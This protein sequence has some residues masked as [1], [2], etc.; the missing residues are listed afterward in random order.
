MYAVYILSHKRAER[1]ETYS[2][3]KDSGY[4]GD[5]FVVVDNEDPQL[6]EYEKR[7]GLE[8]T[9]VF[10]KELY[11]SKSDTITNQK[12]KSSPVYARNFI[13]FHAKSLGYDAYI[14]MD[15][16]ITNLRFRYIENSVAKSQ[17]LS[18][19]FGEV[20]DAYVEYLLSNS[21]ATLSLANVM[22]YAGGVK[23]ADAER[24]LGMHRNTCQIHIRN[25]SYDVDWISL[26]NNDSITTDSTAKLGYLW[27]SLPFVVY[28]SPKMNT[29]PGG[30]KEVYD[31]NSG[32]QR[33]F[34]AT[35]ANPSFCKVGCAKDKLNI[36]RNQKHA[37]PMI[38][39]GRYKKW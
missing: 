14:V 7:F 3:L 12:A 20:L 27:W 30:M 22:I 8:E 38:I 4:K 26:A 9:I 31:S 23:D 17:K 36:H 39:S 37:Y 25:L 18:S 11:I 2:T 24:R 21:I 32:Y 35:I 13:E 6:C 29:L 15:D 33:A 1:V 34:L 10:D 5:V 28:E 16:D 19:T